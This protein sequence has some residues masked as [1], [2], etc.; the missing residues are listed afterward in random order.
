M[1]QKSKIDELV[2]GINTLTPGEK[3]ILL[4][5]LQHPVDPHEQEESEK[6]FWNSFGGW[7]GNETAEELIADI[8]N[9]RTIGTERE[10][11]D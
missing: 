10:P 2:K 9:S 3:L 11:L 8:Y 5:K 7:K 4:R 6:R 1:E